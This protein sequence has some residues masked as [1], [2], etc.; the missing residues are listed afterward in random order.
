MFTGIVQAMGSI[1][2]IDDQRA[3]KRLIIDRRGW[4]LPG[5]ELRHADSVSVSGVCLTLVHVDAQ[6]LAFD[7]IAETLARTT[8]GSLS[9]QSPVNLETSL[10]PATPMSGHFVQGHVEGI[11]TVTQV[12]QGGDDVRMTI[13]MPAALMKYIVPKG[14]VTADGV[15]MTVAG[16]SENRFEM[17]LIPTTLE[18]T[19]LG[20]AQAGTKVNIETDVISRTVVHALEQMAPSVPPATQPPPTAES[21]TLQTLRQAGFIS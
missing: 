17:A 4:Q 6:T 15:S 3:G 16:V 7:V 9:V 19:T 18:M 12:K 1:K 14:S 20:L 2:A 11:G 5:I 21:A 13:E 8:L 10:T